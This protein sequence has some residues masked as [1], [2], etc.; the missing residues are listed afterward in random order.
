MKQIFLKYKISCEH[1]I[2]EKKGEKK[3]KN[4]TFQRITPLFFRLKHTNIM[5]AEAKLVLI[6]L[7]LLSSQLDTC[8]KP[9]RSL[10]GPKI[11]ALGPARTK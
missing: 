1:H 5:E 10:H 7:L 8:F 2:K 11:S 3:V 9:L 6:L 4:Y